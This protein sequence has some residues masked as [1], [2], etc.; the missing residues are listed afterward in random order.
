M[1]DGYLNGSKF[2]FPES[3]QVHPFAN[4]NGQ[5]EC[6]ENCRID[7]FVTIT[8][9]VKLGNNVHLSTGSSIFGVHG[10]TIGNGVS[11]SPG[12]K[13]FTTT[14]DVN[15]G[16]TSNPQL[17]ERGYVAGEVIVQDY[18]VIGANAVVLPGVVIGKGAVLGCL[19]LAKAS[20]M[21]ESIY[22]GIPAG[23]IRPRALEYD[24]QF[25]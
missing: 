7:A 18:A 1:I 12:A 10:V 6:G 11:L 5:V 8:G 2:G 22:A 25:A 20:L 4:I 9:N 13:I 14:E 17:E 21:A 24:L 19:S 23:Y 3:T 16:L 15:S